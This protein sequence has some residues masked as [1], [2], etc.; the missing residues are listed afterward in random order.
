[1]TTVKDIVQFLQQ[2]APVESAEEW[3]NVGL[4]VGD[5]TKAVTAGVICLDITEGAVHEAEKVGAALLISHHP[6]IFRPLRILSSDSVPYQLAVRQ[7]SAVCLHTNLDMAAGG[8][9]DT[10]AEC[11]HLADVAVA[12]DGLCRIGRVAE[13]LDSW[14]FARE[15][16]VR[17]GTAVRASYAKREIRRIAICGGAGG[18]ELLA[19]IRRDPLIDAIVT[20]EFRHHEW[21]EAADR[22]VAVVEAG[23]YATEVP[24]VDTLHAWL[25]RAFPQVCWTIY[26]E[27]SPYRIVE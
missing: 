6:V 9:N 12:A 5:A 17:L 13:P 24:V 8:V 18:E 25:T 1:M 20:G 27:H 7:L 4:L 16:S 15:V 3:D 11:L 19:L 10:L 22:G 21:L 14:A 23:H 2:K 26:R